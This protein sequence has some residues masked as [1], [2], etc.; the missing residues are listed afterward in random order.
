MFFSFPDSEL[1]WS[2]PAQQPETWWENCSSTSSRRSVFSS[3][4]WSLARND[5]GG[6][7]VSS[8]KRRK[9]L[10]WEMLWNI[11]ASWSFLVRR[12][13]ISGYRLWGKVYP[14]E[15]YE[16]ILTLCWPVTN[17]LVFIEQRY[18]L[19]ACTESL[20]SPTQFFMH[21]IVISFHQKEYAFKRIFGHILLDWKKF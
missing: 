16:D 10:Y 3:S 18:W 9:P 1:V 14:T 21:K 15:Y 5:P 17:V 12:S 11:E 8:S 13:Q 7:S 19:K 2:C 20:V 6:A 4:T